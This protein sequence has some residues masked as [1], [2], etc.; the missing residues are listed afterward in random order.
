MDEREQLENELLKAQIEKERVQ[1][2]LAE[3]QLAEMQRKKEFRK[4]MKETLRTIWEWISI[5]VVGGVIVYGFG[6]AVLLLVDGVC[7][8]FDFVVLW[9]LPMLVAVYFLVR[10]EIWLIKR[11]KAKK[12]E[13]TEE[14]D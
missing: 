2:R 5:I 9:A 13:E 8:Y 4:K 3:E 7:H 6:F 10:L 14:E 1:Q 12:K 11:R